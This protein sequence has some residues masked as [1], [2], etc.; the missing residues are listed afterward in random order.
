MQAPPRIKF[1]VRPALHL[2]CATPLIGL[3]YHGLH[4][5]L[6][7]NPIEAVIRTLGDW[8]LR[9]LV[10]ALAVTPLRRLSGWPALAVYRRMAGLWGFAYALLH[11]LGYVVLDQFFDWAAIGHDI[12]KHRFITA[13]MA[14]FALLLPLALTSTGGMV[15]RLGGRSWRR[16]HRLVYVAVPLASIH[17]IWM[18]KAD[19]RQPLIYAGL[20]ALFLLIRAVGARWSQ[21]SPVAGA[22]TR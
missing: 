4:G 2:L 6:G 16:L 10:V 1:L 18:V 20:V 3:A 15:R 8:A 19:I 17:Y 5:L 9:L 22:P 11:L 21:R 12:L 13:G 7:A 14:A